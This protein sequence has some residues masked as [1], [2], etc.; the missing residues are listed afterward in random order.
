MSSIV[1]VQLERKLASYSVNLLNCYLLF[2]AMQILIITCLFSNLCI[3]H[4]S[5]GMLF[6]NKYQ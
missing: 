6:M 3:L 2:F 5:L 4:S 1:M